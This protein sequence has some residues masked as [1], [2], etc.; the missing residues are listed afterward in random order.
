MGCI[1][2]YTIHCMKEEQRQRF[3][4]L[5]AGT[6]MAIM[7]LCQDGPY[8]D[9]ECTLPKSSNRLEYYA[10]NVQN[11]IVIAKNGASINYL[12]KILQLEL[13]LYHKNQFYGEKERNTKLKKN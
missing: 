12:L 7:E 10:F 1:K 13:F 9:G 4:A 11:T 6:N 5:Y 8:Q 3:N 2:S